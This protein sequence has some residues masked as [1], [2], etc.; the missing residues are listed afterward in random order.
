M[1]AA[2]PTA[3]DVWTDTLLVDLGLRN[4]T[5]GQ[6][7]ISAGQFR[8]RVDTGVTVSHYDAEQRL[9]TVPAGGTVQTRISYLL[10]PHA[11]TV[12]LE[13]TEAGE[14]EPIGLPLHPTRPQ[15]A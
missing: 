2:S 5:D 7:R 14:T 8:L 11:T 3:H 4:N 9:V 1:H 13:Y 6:R 10:P 12:S 15:G